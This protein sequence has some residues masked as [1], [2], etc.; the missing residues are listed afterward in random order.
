MPA[1]IVASPSCRELTAGPALFHDR[2]AMFP[3]HRPRRLR[4]NPVFRD[5]IRETRLP[6]DSLI[7]PMFVVPGRGV[8]TEVSAMPGVHLHSIDQLVD[9]CRR[10]ADLGIRS[11]MLFGQPE[12]KDEQGSGAWIEHGIIQ[13]ATTALKQALPR[14]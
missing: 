9:E 5:M 11:V 2:T 12:A 3:T 4:Q 13:R 7:Y 14:L 1:L 6:V 8:K 10:V